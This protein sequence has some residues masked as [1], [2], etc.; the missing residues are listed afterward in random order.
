MKITLLIFFLCIA[1]LVHG[2]DQEAYDSVK[3]EFTKVVSVEGMNAQ[4]LYSNA[5]LFIAKAFVSAK[6]VTQLADEKSNT[7]VAKGIFQIPYEGTGAFAYLK[8]FLTR[9]TLEIRTKDNKYQYILNDFIVAQPDF[10][11]NGDNL[12]E[13]YAKKKGEMNKK[14]HKKLW[15]AMKASA[16]SYVQDFTKDLEDQMKKKNDF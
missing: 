9:F 5:K 4:T 15:D 3:F 10:Y 14:G 11:Y 2:Q 12:S 1:N 8:D 7:I 16:Y 13:L 6:E